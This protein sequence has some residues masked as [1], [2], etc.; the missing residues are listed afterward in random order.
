M[1]TE[2]DQAL[3]E[4]EKVEIHRYQVE[5]GLTASMLTAVFPHALV[6]WLNR[7]KFFKYIGARYVAVAI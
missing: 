2:T 7:V 3:L 5:S 4:N 6:V 1:K